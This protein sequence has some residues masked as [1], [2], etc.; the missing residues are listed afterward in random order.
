MVRLFRGQ[1]VVGQ[2]ALGHRQQAQFTE[3]FQGDVVR[4]TQPQGLNGDVRLQNLWVGPVGAGKQARMFD[5]RGALIQ[6]L[7]ALGLAQQAAGQLQDLAGVQCL[8][9]TAGLAHLFQGLVEASRQVRCGV[10]VLRIA[11][12]HDIPGSGSFA[13]GRAARVTLYPKMN[14]EPLTRQALR[15][16][17]L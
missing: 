5:R 4:R 10:V 3:G 9:E 11:G 2:L 15:S 6:L 17:T 8:G 7:G 1:R 12:A 14:P 16:A 13:A